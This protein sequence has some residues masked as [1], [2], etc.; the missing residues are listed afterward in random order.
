M[1]QW[2]KTAHFTFWMVTSC[3]ALSGVGYIIMQ[4]T[5]G[6]EARIRE[7]IGRTSTR[8]T[9]EQKARNQA[10]LDM[11]KNSKENAND[12]PIWRK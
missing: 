3:A 9:D 7:D 1:S 10:I 4:G 2:L 12:V 8:L 5:K 11:I 6:D